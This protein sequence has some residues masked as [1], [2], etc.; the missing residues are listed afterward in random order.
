MSGHTFKFLRGGVGLLC[1]AALFGFIGVPTSAASGA[2]SEEAWFSPY[3]RLCRDGDLMSGLDD[4]SFSPEGM[5]S[6]ADAVVYAARLWSVV[7]DAEELLE[8]TIEAQDTPSIWYGD[9]SW[10][11]KG[12]DV[13]VPYKNAVA[14]LYDIDSGTMELLEKQL[15]KLDGSAI[16]TPISREDFFRLMGSYQMPQPVAI[17]RE[18]VSDVEDMG[19]RLLIS[20][21]VVVGMEKGYEFERDLTQAEAA[22]LLSRLKHPE[23]RI[24]GKAPPPHMPEQLSQIHLA[25]GGFGQVLSEYQLDLSKGELWQF[26][27]ELGA[28]EWDPEA[29]NS[30]YQTVKELS[31][32][33]REEFQSSEGV[34]GA[35]LWGDYY[36]S[37]NV[38]DGTQWWLTFV[39]DD[40]SRWEIFGSNA[41]PTDWA[42]FEAAFGALL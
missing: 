15:E 33:E 7:L 28:P 22:A 12:S 6:Y 8:G 3:V 27:T 1:T 21:G 41:F 13:G 20:T 37:P 25:F 23:L 40:G 30:G 2:I 17:R 34:K 18:D 4:D 42:D 5:V 14:Y 10:Q 31:A 29:E 32:E 11:E 36:A 38:F 26:H 19:I 16:D 35:L 39:F 9:G 24:M